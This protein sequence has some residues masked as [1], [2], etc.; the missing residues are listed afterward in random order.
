MGKTNRTFSV[1]DEYND[2]FEERRKELGMSVTAYFEHIIDTE[3]KKAQAATPVEIVKDNP[4]HISKIKALEETIAS[5]N[6]TEQKVKD[7]E[8]EI[9]NF[10]KEIG[11]SNLVN[12]QLKQQIQSLQGRKFAADN[13][14]LLQIDPINIKI[15]EY[16]AEREG[17]KRNQ[18]W[19]ISD[20]INWFIHYR[21]EVGTINGGFDS[22]PDRV[23]RGM[24]EDLIGNEDENV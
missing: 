23:I 21:F 15:L 6:L 11:Q 4:E 20:V 3:H 1:T 10:Q 9:E 17:K 5:N 12:E 14:S 16:V 19:T 22:V 8:K 7:Y 2:I 13:D 18:E 24:K